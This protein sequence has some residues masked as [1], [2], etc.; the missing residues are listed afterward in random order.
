MFHKLV[1]MG[2]YKTLKGYLLTNIGKIKLIDC[3][4]NLVQFHF[5]S[6][7]GFLVNVLGCTKLKFVIEPVFSVNM[8]LHFKGFTLKSLI[9][10]NRKS[11]IRKF[12]RYLIKSISA[13]CNFSAINR[14][15]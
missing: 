15:N 14:L 2:I 8:T 7:I 3:S 9:G 4:F 5:T 13:L 10:N 6:S 1:Y 12:S 11:W